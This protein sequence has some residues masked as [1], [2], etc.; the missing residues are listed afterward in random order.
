[1]GSQRAGKGEAGG[2]VRAAGSRPGRLSR[3]KPWDLQ[4]WRGLP[5]TGNRWARLPRDR[6]IS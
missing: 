5:E 6:I 1:M 4:S 2:C 3:H